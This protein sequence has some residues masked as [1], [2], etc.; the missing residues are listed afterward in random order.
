MNY[1]HEK[2]IKRKEENKKKK[3]NLNTFLSVIILFSSIF[4]TE[5]FFSF[6]DFVFP[7]EGLEVIYSIHSN[8][9]A[10]HL[11]QKQKKNDARATL[12]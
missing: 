1:Y 6:S 9:N 12:N 5:Y 8:N 4:S 11:N 7:F 3:K 10:L 2:R